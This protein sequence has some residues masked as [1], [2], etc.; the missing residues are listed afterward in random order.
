[1]N[2]EQIFMTRSHFSKNSLIGKSLAI[3]VLLCWLA[4]VA[5]V[6][7]TTAANAETS[8]L[9]APTEAKKLSPMPVFKDYKGV[10]VGMT[11][12]EIREKLGKP[13]MAD[14]AGFYYV[15]SDDESAQINL[16]ADK[17]ASVIVIFYAAENKNAPAYADV[18]GPEANVAAKDDGSI[19]NLVRYPEA[20]FWVAYNRPAGDK[21]IVTVTIQKL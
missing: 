15:F 2:A 14:D 16:D 13:K 9:T 11:A 4:V 5:A 12:D 8:A 21:A 10:T 17:K 1:M 3:P 20:G 6:G 18:F 19:Y 7:Q